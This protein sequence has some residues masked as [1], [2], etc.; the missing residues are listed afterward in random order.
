MNNK[1]CKNCLKEVEETLT[2]FD[3]ERCGILDISETCDYKTVKAI[4]EDLEYE[5]RDLDYFNNP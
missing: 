5:R 2:G 1:Y 3:C 4:K